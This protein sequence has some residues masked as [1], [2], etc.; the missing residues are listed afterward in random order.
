MEGNGMPDKKRIMG[1]VIPL[2]AG[3]LLTAALL[4]FMA[5]FARYD[6]M[7]KDTS[8]NFYRA[9]ALFI[10]G[11]L[12]ICSR[13]SSNY[14]TKQD[15]LKAA[16]AGRS[17]SVVSMNGIEF[18]E[19]SG[20][21]DTGPALGAWQPSLKDYIG[22]YT[23]NAAGNHGYLS[24]RAGG[25]YLYGTIRFPNWGRG[26][27]EYLKNVGIANGKLY[28]TR[29]VTTQQELRRLGANAYFIQQYSGEY[30]RSGNLIRGFYVVNKER[31]QWE[32]YKSR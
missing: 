23:V 7:V 24:L 20:K 18:I 13:D 5:A 22:D 29:S 25:G 3:I 14:T 11:N 26:G 31:K 32:A 21:E 6:A 2:G 8:G 1:I 30:L 10:A 27:T 17:L 12:F 19:I 16:S 9:R 4:F 28:F 15:A